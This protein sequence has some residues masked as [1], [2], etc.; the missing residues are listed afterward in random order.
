M[1]TKP[2]PS[3][4]S[5]TTKTKAKKPTMAQLTD[6]VAAQKDAMTKI[7]TYM[8]VGQGQLVSDKAV[9]CADALEA[10]DNL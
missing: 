6:Q 2:N 5:N 3:T 10:I 1:T 4:K 8:R 7:G 9:A